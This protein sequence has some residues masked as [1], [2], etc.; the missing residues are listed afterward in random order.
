MEIAD[1]FVIN[2]AD[3]PGVAE[4][5]RDLL[6]MLDVATPEEGGWVPPVVRAVGTSGEGADAV[7]DAVAHH[8]AWLVD[9]GRLERRRRDRTAE[10]LRGIL[11]ARLHDRVRDLERGDAFARACAAVAARDVDPWTASDDLL[12]DL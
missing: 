12:E 5:E 2:K 8:R 11:V 9:T 3:R 7:V 10:E 4:T 6:G 1:V